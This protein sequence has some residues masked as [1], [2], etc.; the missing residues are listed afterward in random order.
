[1]RARSG[2]LPTDPDA[3]LKR[4]YRGGKPGD[5]QDDWSAFGEIGQLLDEQIAPPEISA[6]LFKAAA[7][8]PGVALVDKATDATGRTGVAI[9]HTYR[10][11]RQEWIFDADTYE[12]L[13][14]REVLVEPYR[15]LKPGAVTTESVVVKRAVV[16]AKK[17]LP[18]GG[19]I[20]SGG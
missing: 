4:L 17:E 18:G 13:G 3:L 8:I 2:T 1:M 11:S 6:A 19:T 12:Y 9:T 10:N 14:R 15:G 7:E 5:A 20:N 16:S